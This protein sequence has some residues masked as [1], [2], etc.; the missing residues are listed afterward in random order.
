[1]MGPLLNAKTK[2]IT[3][4]GDRMKERHI[5]PEEMGMNDEQWNTFKVLHGNPEAEYFITAAVKEKTESVNTLNRPKKIG[6]KL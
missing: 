6:P 1:M 3:H 2:T 4:T 5:Y